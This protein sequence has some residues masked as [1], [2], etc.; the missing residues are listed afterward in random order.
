MQSNRRE[1]I[2][3]ASAIGLGVGALSLTLTPTD[4]MALSPSEDGL[5][6]LSRN[7]HLLNRISFGINQES[8]RSVNRLGYRRYIEQQLNPDAIDDTEIEDYID[9]YLP[10]VNQSI[11][12]TR[13]QVKARAIPRLRVADELAMAT[14]LRAIYS[15]K[16]LL[17]VMVEFW[18]NHFSVYHLDGPVVFLKTQ[19][20]KEVIR[21]LALSS[22]SQLLHASAKSPAMIYYLDGYA[23]TKEAPN[24]NYARE[25]MELHT[26]GVDGPYTHH[27]IDEVARCFT[28][29]QIN[30]RNG[31]FRFNRRDHDND[32]K[33][34][35]GHEIAK[36]GGVSDGEQVL[37][38]LAA[39]SATAVFLAEKL[40]QHFIADNPSDAIIES[41]TN[42]FIESKGNI[43]ACLR[44][45]LLSDEFINSQGQKLKRPFHYMAS[46]TRSLNIKFSDR[47]SVRATRQMF[48]S[49]GQRPFFWQSPDGY[50]DV[51][52]YWESTT[53]MLFRWN[54]VNDVS[55][56]N[57]PG[58]QYRLDGLIS[59][60]YSPE[61]IYRQITDKILFRQMSNEDKRVMLDYLSDGA[62]NNNISPIKIQGALA[63]AMGSP[64]FQL[65]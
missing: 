58:Y 13:L 34:V 47:R 31:Q 49:L 24:E 52:S 55:F 56:G 36:F 6:E 25:L 2:K 60:P 20:D 30:Q 57:F 3:Q 40:C 23:S 17:Q 10:T 32:E 14:Y 50:P 38:I 43:K 15:K 42:T 29:W 8:M 41:T 35:L 18:N 62:E 9:E 54:F 59:K 1:F 12:Q 26:L 4:L 46:V 5:P 39:Q 33:I 16:Q 37:D 61:N 28:G 64:Y 7:A 63:L 45:I 65:N 22:F 48:D 21:P 11:V 27:D 53:G 51:A 44:H 19:E